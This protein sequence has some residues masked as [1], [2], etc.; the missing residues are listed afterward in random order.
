LVLVLA[1]AMSLGLLTSYLVYRSVNRPRVQQAETE[2]VAVAAANIAVGEAL[3]S[4]HI[5]LTPWPKATVLPG[6]LRSAKD[7]DGRVARVSIVAGEPILESKLAPAG[8]G[9][10]MP[11]LVPTG[12]RA[13]SIIVEQAIQKSGF[14]LPN[15]RVDVLVT[16][17]RRQGESKES[18]I[19]LQDVTVLAADQTV[20]MKDNKPVTMT[21]V[22]MALAPE[23][24]ERLALAQ[25]E[26]RV[27]L[28]LRNMQDTARVP[29]PGVTTAQ[30]LG[31]PAPAPASG[32]NSSP[33]RGSAARRA[34]KPAVATTN[35]ALP[36]KAPA[37]QPSTSTH[38]VSVIRGVSATETVFVQDPDRGWLE[39]PGRTG[40]TKKP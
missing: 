18:R 29:T 32:K 36:V 11:V 14:V 34:P 27:T 23:E 1:L 8:G 5:K 3:T 6:S 40:A 30:L 26:G 10:L 2:Q 21:T 13:V 31:S 20:E 12:K 37:V 28:A 24:A 4:S 22:T 38:T 17:A 33:T 15:S 39:T 9:G 16:M 7:L 35:P 19:V 25:N